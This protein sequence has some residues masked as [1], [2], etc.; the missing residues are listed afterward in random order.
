MSWRFS[1]HST[2]PCQEKS[3][4]ERCSTQTVEARSTMIRWSEWWILGLVMFHYLCVVV[5]YIEYLLCC[6][7]VMFNV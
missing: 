4:L 5:V 2:T 7:L 6:I 3:S 1:T